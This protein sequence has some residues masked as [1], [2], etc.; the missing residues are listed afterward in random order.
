[1]TECSKIIR[2]GDE[3]D[4]YAIC[5]MYVYLTCMLI[6]DTAEFAAIC[7]AETCM[8]F[9][10]RILTVVC[11]FLLARGYRRCPSACLEFGMEIWGLLWTGEGHVS[12]RSDRF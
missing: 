4:M 5:D 6:H 3:R 12:W 10:P 7:K 9:P 11:N 1:M 8:Q 2:E